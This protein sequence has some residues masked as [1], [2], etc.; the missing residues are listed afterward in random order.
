MGSHT[1]TPVPSRPRL[2]IKVILLLTYVYI[3]RIKFDSKHSLL[4]KRE[5]IHWHS[6]PFVFLFLKSDTWRQDEGREK[7]NTLWPGTYLCKIN[8]NNFINVKS[9]THLYPKLNVL[10]RTK[11]KYYR[12][13]RVSAFSNREYALIC[14]K[15]KKAKQDGATWEQNIILLVFPPR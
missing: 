8:V 14:Q 4:H 2:S 12:K 11:V 1:K 9:S 7:R 3:S 6:S 10:D 13:I 5:T 15:E